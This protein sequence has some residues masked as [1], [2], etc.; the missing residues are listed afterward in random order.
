VKREIGGR[1]A[2]LF[3][4]GQNVPENL[5]DADDV[6]T[7]ARIKHPTPIS[8]RQYGSAVNHYGSDRFE[9]SQAKARRIIAQELHR[10]GWNEHDL[11]SRR[12]G[13]PEKVKL[14]RRLRAETTMTLAWVAQALEMGRW[15]YVS[16]LLK[17]NTKSANIED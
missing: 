6:A 3:A 8:A 13:D 10:L 7:H 9:T 1:A 5:P 15:G 11:Q 16:H 12:K 14:A 2:H 4:R 17:G